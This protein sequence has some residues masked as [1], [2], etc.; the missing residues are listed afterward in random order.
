MRGRR[1]AASFKP[2][3]VDASDHKQAVESALALKVEC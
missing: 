3:D 1:P 2:T